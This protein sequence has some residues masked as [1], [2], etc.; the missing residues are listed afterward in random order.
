MN[1]PCKPEFETQGLSPACRSLPCGVE[2]RL[3]QVSAF[4]I[5][6]SFLILSQIIDFRLR[7]SCP[8]QDGV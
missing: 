3:A 2:L 1:K 4:R 7:H 8:T 6:N 5:R